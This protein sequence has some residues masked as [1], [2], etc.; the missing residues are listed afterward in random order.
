M[1]QIQSKKI[2]QIQNQIFPIKTA[3]M[4]GWGAKPEKDEC[5]QRM[6]D[7]QKEVIRKN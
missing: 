6:A 1:V 7:V 2:R 5:E 3:G 4:C